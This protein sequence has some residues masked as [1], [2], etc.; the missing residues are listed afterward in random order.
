VY[1]WVH[2]AASTPLPPDTRNTRYT[3]TL[4]DR[5]IMTLLI[6]HA[7]CNSCVI[8][9]THTQYPHRQEAAHASDVHASNRNTAADRATQ[10]VQQQVSEPT[11]TELPLS[12][13]TCADGP[14]LPLTPKP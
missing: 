6:V 3:R 11:H 9:D 13:W 8:H 5:V 2:A 12:A 4:L 1:S 7:F 14:A 10:H